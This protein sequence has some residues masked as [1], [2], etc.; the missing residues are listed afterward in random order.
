MSFARELYA[1]VR[2]R[3]WAQ[4]HSNVHSSIVE[5]EKR[6][7]IVQEDPVQLLDLGRIMEREG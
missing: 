4:V 3:Q 2:M 5:T 6:K 1:D 7:P